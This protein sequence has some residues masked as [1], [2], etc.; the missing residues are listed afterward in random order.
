MKE[1]IEKKSL[2]KILRI[3]LILALLLFGLIYINKTVFRP[4]F[5]TTH[6]EQ[7]LTGSFPNFIAALLISLCVVNPVLNKKPR[8]GRLI[9]YAFSLCVMSVLILDE[10]KSIAASEIFDI[11]DIIGSISGS[12]IAILIYEYLYYRLNLKRNN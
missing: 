10:I 5:N 9:V 1:R 6:F 7:I 4:T 2:R 8:F 11:C 3:N 12:V